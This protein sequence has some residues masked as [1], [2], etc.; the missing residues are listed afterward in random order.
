MARP[1]WL[2]VPGGQNTG[3]DLDGQLGLVGLAQAETAPQ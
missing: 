3:H 1:G 2:I